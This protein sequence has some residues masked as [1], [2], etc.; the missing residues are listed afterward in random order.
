MTTLLAGVVMLN[1]AIDAAP[2][3]ARADDV[4]AAHLHLNGRHAVQR[5]GLRT[6]LCTTVRGGQRQTC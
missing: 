2:L 3:A 1:G 4:S 5:Q 6:Q